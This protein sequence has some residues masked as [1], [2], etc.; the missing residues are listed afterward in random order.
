MKTLAILPALNEAGKIERVIEKTKPYVTTVLVVDDG[1]TDGT[2]E[3]AQTVG[4]VVLR[5]QQNLGVGAAIRSGIEYALSNSFDVCIPL[6]ADDQDNPHEI[7]RLLAAINEGY[8]LVIG[9]RYLIGGKCENIPFFRLATT[10]SYTL[11]FRLLAKF[12]LTDGSNGFRAFRLSLF[13]D[14]RINLWQ[15][16]LN[17]YELEPY[18]LYKIIILKYKVKEVPVT[19]KYH[20][21]E[22]YTKM[23]PFQ[24]WW[25]ITKPLIYLRIGIKK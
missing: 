18:L 11:F 3:I 21:K 12:P 9:S 13:Q 7:P 8:H 24:D 16:W 6:G 15:E 10:K 23:V 19:K 25:R 2:A 17:R 14:K 20:R 22:G 5:H 1:S 4:A